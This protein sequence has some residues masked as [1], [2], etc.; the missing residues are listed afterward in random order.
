MNVLGIAGFFAIYIAVP[1]IVVSSRPLSW[2]DDDLAATAII[3]LPPSLASMIGS[4]LTGRLV[5]ARDARWSSSTVVTVAGATAG[6]GLVVAGLGPASL[7]SLM[8][9]LTLVG[10]GAGGAFNGIVEVV[11]RSGPVATRTGT[12][13]AGR[14]IGGAL[15][16]ALVAVVLDRAGPRMGST[17]A[18]GLALLLLAGL[19]FLGIIVWVSRS[20]KGTDLPPGTG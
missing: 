20:T 12:L 15:G 8:V 16:G 14:Y 17:G 10:L 9:G 3:L 13:V 18:V 2:T 6:S 4:Q 19:Q 1:T 11:S 7:P 5:R